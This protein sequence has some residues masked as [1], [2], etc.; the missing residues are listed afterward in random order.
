[1]VCES[2]VSNCFPIILTSI[3]ARACLIPCGVFWMAVT[4]IASLYKPGILPPTNPPMISTFPARKS[5]TDQTSSTSLIR[6]LS[7]VR[8]T[9]SRDNDSS[10]SNTTTLGDI[11]TWWTKALLISSESIITNEAVISLASVGMRI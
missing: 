2:V 3:E 9:A 10:G 5:F 4:D 11:W 1:M 8:A 6:T 7:V